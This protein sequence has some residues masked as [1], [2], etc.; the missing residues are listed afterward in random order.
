MSSTKRKS[1]GTVPRSPNAP[2]ASES[3]LDSLSDSAAKKVKASATLMASSGLDTPKVTAVAA[4]K[5]ITMQ[6]SPGT[7]A[8]S[9][10]TLQSNTK[11]NKK[12]AAKKES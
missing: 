12:A 10:K 3:S 8:G 7:A 5:D 4:S 2:G 11:R 6:V 1:A 9:T